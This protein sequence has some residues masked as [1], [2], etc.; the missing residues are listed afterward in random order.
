MLALDTAAAL[1]PGGVGTLL[2]A[3]LAD[4]DPAY[5]RAAIA[6]APMPVPPAMR[7][8]LAAAVA[9]DRDPA[10]ALDAAAVLCADLAVDPARPILDA[11][12]APG[13]A[14]L[15]TL[16]KAGPPAAIRDPARCLAPD[17]APASPA[18]LRGI[19]R[20]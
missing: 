2:D 18:A 16:V 14:R 6:L 11:L 1:D 19:R 13:L 12:A 8:A 4:P 9:G 3:A 20:P 5:R 17:P 7:G 10:V 15:R